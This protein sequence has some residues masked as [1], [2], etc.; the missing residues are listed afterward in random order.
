M[1]DPV[2]VLEE[3][4]MQCSVCGKN[5]YFRSFIL[6]DTKPYKVMTVKDCKGCGLTETTE[7]DCEVLDY[8]VRVSCDFT[9]NDDSS[10]DLR[11]MAF[12]NS[13]AETIIY[14]NDSGNEPREIFSFS[15]ERGNIDCIEGLVM[16]GDGLLSSS[17]ENADVKK[18]HNKLKEIMKGKG[19]KIVIVDDT[20]YSRVCPVGVEYTEVQNLTLDELSGMDPQVLYEKIPKRKE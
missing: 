17:K 4:E 9:R 6:K 2:Q 7:D 10:S 19:F 12:I 16:R 3:K 14:E 5:A 1:K 13:R 8:G 11:R 15:A 20:G 18:I